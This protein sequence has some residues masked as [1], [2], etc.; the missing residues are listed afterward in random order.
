MT[1]EATITAF[2][3]AEELVSRR[4]PLEALRTLEPVL[5]VDSD[6]PSVQLLLGRAYFFSSQLQRAENAFL[7]VLDFDPTDHY[8]R[9]A[10]G[11]TLQRQG[12][13]AE[14]RAQLRLA[15]TMHPDEPAYREAL[16]EINTNIALRSS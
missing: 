16:G 13:L 6:K 7:R 11:R 2:R 5:D 8:A 4:R 14:A 1:S 15:V 3:R 10:L 12:R 9:L